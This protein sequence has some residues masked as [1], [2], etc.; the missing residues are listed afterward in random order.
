MQQDECNSDN[1][2]ETVNTPKKYENRAYEEVISY[3]VYLANSGPCNLAI[4]NSPKLYL[5][6]LTQVVSYGTHLYEHEQA[7][8]CEMRNSRTE[9][10]SEQLLVSCYK[11]FRNSFPGHGVGKMLL[12]L[13]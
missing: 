3:E 12:L 9:A 7:R 1:V 4:T 10:K 2:N 5:A 6:R 13:L 11:L 8:F